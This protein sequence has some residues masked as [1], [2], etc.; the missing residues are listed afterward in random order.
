LLVDIAR[1]LWD[2][3]PVNHVESCVNRSKAAWLLSLPLSAAGMLL[4]HEF[5]WEFGGHQH[6]DEAAH[7]YL[8]YLAIFAALGTATLIIAAATQLVR[9]VAGTG[10]AQAPPA[11]VFAIVPIIG[12]LLQEHLEHVVAER[13]LHVTFFVSAP[14]LLGLA[15]QIPFALAALLV[16]RLIL[17]LVARVARAVGS[18]RTMPRL[19]SLVVLMPLVP[20]LS[21]R[22]ALATRAAGRAPPHLR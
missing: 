15:L 16:A 18:P 21:P 7:G 9:G 3:F 13:E 14:F 12:F 11:R 8:Q 6:A 5:A 20:E 2:C 10:V 22:P 19:A 1:A 17:G 4:A